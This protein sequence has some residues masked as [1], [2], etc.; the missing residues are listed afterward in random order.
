MRAHWEFA[1]WAV[2]ALGY[3]GI[4]FEEIFEFDK[5]GIG[6]LMAGLLWVIYRFVSS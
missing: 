6:L 4:I 2:F 3:V 1:M 5:C